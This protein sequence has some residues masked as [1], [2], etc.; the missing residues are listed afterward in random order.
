MH[1]A[2]AVNLHG[3]LR[4]ADFASDLL[5]HEPGRNE[6]RHFVLARRQGRELGPHLFN[7]LFACTAGAVP[8]ESKS[9]RVEHFLIPK[10]LLQKPDCSSRSRRLVH[11]TKGSGLQKHARI[12]RLWRSE[13]P[14]DGALM[15]LPRRG[16]GLTR[17]NHLIWVDICAH[18]VFCEIW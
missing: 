7:R 16:A 12:V 10:G 14:S 3:D 18:R 11:G 8:F 6:S 15:Q 17:G 5:V 9:D 2:A 13:F 4:H 1:D